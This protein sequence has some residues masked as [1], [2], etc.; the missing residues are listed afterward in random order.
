MQQSQS[1]RHSSKSWN[2]LLILQCIVF[3]CIFFSFA[4]NLFAESLLETDFNN[5]NNPCAVKILT[6]QVVKANKNLAQVPQ[7]GWQNVQLPDN[8]EN[9]WPGYSGSVWYRIVWEYRCRDG[10]EKRPLALLIDRI[11]IAGI[12]YSNNELIWH[13]K[14][15]VKPLSRSWNMPRFWILPSTSLNQGRNEVL[16]RVVGVATQNSGLGIV[17]I[18]NAEKINNMHEKLMFERRTLYFINLLITLVFGT[19]SFLIWLFRRREI[20]FGWFALNCLFWALFVSN[21]LI[22]EPF[23]F[24]D[25]LIHS[26][27]NLI[28]LV[29]YAY[30]LC[31]FVWRFANVIFA[32]VEK[33]LLTLTL[34]VT[35][36]LLLIP[37]QYLSIALNGAF[38]YSTITF[39][40]NCIFVQWIAYKK[41]KFDIYLLAIVFLLF[42]IIICH[43][44]YL[45][46]S[47]QFNKLM[48]TPFAAPITSLA[49]SFILAWRI[50]KN[51]R[52]IEKFNRTLKETV[53]T[54]TFDLE[55]S[56][57]KKHQLEI[58]NMRLQE[59]LNLA[60]D[61]HDG[62]GGS[63]VRSMILLEHSEKIE[64]P[65]VLS[66]FKLLRN[67]LRQVIDSGSSIGAK[68]PE[69]PIMWVAPLRHRF[70]QLF[71]EMDIQSTW[72][73]ANQWELIPHPLHC[74]TLSR[75]AEEALTNIIKH[76]QATKV[77]LSLVE[78][79]SQ[80]LIL[81]I[82]DNG[83]GFIATTVQQGLHVGLQSMQ[84]RVKRIGGEFEIH[85]ETGLTVIRAIVPQKPRGVT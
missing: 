40:S 81:E 23:P 61:L 77:E 17:S 59:R 26:R 42:I 43:D 30:T 41:R 36:I 6:T 34:V 16:V 71:E 63:I 55:Q 13:D 14:S 25:S 84:V 70:V 83:Q 18:D 9:R 58:E 80:R 39:V 46:Q 1:N 21:L 10:Q 68:V 8:W 60:H 35:I 50:A 62:L 75:V 38:L 19:T 44:L 12:V 7:Q 76:S 28:F 49:I 29:A 66:M 79:D 65:Q 11:I 24:T 54:V 4:Q 32:T 45:L 20:A 5:H 31:L 74:L 2:T 3:I 51:M 72:T 56:L 57:D 33:I 82:R 73:L 85:S 67:D 53:E 64:K 22:T 37:D 78:D 15:L 47:K 69:S 52:H 48:W 27:L